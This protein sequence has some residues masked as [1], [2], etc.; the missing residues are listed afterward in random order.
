MNFEERVK[1]QEFKLND[2][3]DEI[4]DYIRTNRER[5]PNLSIQ[6]VAQDLYIVPNAIMRLCRKLGYTGYSQLKILLQTEERDGLIVDKLFNQNIHKSIDLINYDTLK[7]VASKM[8]GCKIIHF[9]GVG[10]S[11]KY[12]EMMTNYMEVYDFR[13]KN[14]QTYRE[15][16]YRIQHASEKELL[17][18]ISASGRNSRINEWLKIAKKNGVTIISITHFGDNELSQ[19]ADIPIYFWG[20]EQRQNG[21]NVTDRCGLD[22]VLRELTEL[23][24]QMYC[25]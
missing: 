21:Y 7:D 8:Y 19:L 23:F 15:I 13:A 24:W 20:P 3:D 2:T 14:Y 5:I 17:F 18:I 22:I 12:C 6:K 25:T 1:Q 16:E 9:I 11:L 4:V 10:D